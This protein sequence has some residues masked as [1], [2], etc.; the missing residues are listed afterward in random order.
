M[1]AAELSEQGELRPANP[2][3]AGARRRFVSEASWVLLGQAIGAIG[4]VAGVRILTQVLSPA[5]FGELALAMTATTLAL[6]VLLG[7]LATTT[8]RFFAPAQEARQM[9]SFLE[10]VRDL[11][12]GAAGLITVLGTVV[13]VC[14]VAISGWQWFVL[15]GSALAFALLSGTSSVLD[16]MQNAARQ[17]TVVAWHDGCAPWL[18]AGLAVILIHA[19]SR[20]TSGVAMAGYA[21]ASA[22]VLCSQYFFFRTRIRSLAAGDREGAADR[23]RWIRD[24]LVYGSPFALWGVFTWAQMASDRWA[25]GV[26]VSTHEVGLYAAVYQLGFYPL[27]MLSQVL[28]QFAA[29]VLFRRAG[30]ASD[31]DR[32]RASRI[33]NERLLL[34]VLGSTVLITIVSALLHRWIAL[35]LLAPEYR[36]AS[37]FFPWMTLAGGLFATGQVAA[38]G[39]MTA[40][41][42]RSMTAPKII[43]ALVGVALNLAG[44]FL[45]GVAGVV[46][47]GV[48]TAAIYCGWLILLAAQNRSDGN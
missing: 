36:S 21:L 46:G 48:I 5:S 17:R 38:L 2:S 12:A 18:R 14:V 7:P 15:A 37:H 10:A 25:L 28:T 23:D 27:V 40:N 39:F 24:I 6:Q 9:R 30:D 44:A 42:V 11:L 8:L 45:Y 34:A 29:P 33:A 3:M 20:A 16:G 43:T 19:L 26:L 47:A 31:P 32:V 22:C 13:L 4:S 1:K 35:L 41:R